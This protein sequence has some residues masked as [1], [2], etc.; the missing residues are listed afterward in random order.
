MNLFV[1]GHPVKHS[2][3]PVIHNYWLKKYK[4]KEIYGKLD[5]SGNELQDIIKKI[6]RRELIG[7]NVTIPHKQKIYSLLNNL[8]LNAK[9][10]LAVNTIYLKNNEVY[11]ENTDGKGFCEALIQEK[12]F[13]FK[14]KEI[15]L[16]GAG[17]ASYGIIS[18]LMNREVSKI[19]ISNR[20]IKKAEKLIQNFKN[21]TIQIKL[22]KWEKL[23]PVESTDLIINTT[24]IGLKKGEIIDINLE[25]LSKKVIYSDLIYN[26]KKTETMKKFEKKGFL[27]QNG[28]GMLVNQ[29]ARSFK[30][31]FNINL[32]NEDIEE[33]KELCEKSN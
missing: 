4:R 30:L 33:A 11:G 32:T 5:V 20:T 9:N 31:W 13:S 10:S 18:E 2:L 27:T 23:V 14:H 26:P 29:A 17:G 24:S 28:L 7:V 21:N 19:F 16:L 3:S 6:H 25:H 1:I 22:L 8:D 12:K 15:L